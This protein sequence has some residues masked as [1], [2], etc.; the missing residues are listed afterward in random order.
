MSNYITKPDTPKFYNKACYIRTT[1]KTRFTLSMGG[2][3]NR[4]N[5]FNQI[6]ERTRENH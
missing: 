1:I 4:N 2:S 3:Y 5:I 6:L